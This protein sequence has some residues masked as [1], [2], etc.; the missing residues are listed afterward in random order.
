VYGW[1]V[2]VTDKLLKAGWPWNLPHPIRPAMLGL[3]RP[4]T[5]GLTAIERGTS[6][7]AL[8]SGDIAIGIPHDVPVAGYQAQNT[9]KRL[10]LWRAEATE[11][12]ISYAFNIGD[13]DGRRAGRSEHGEPLQ[14]ALPQMTHRRRAGA[15]GS[16]SQHFFVSCRPHML[17][18]SIC[19]SCP[20]ANFPIS[21]GGAAQRQ[22]IPRI[23]VAELIG[24]AR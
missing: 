19:A 10:R 14:G 6:G 4:H 17:R 3:R 21:W 13:Y 1:Q 20:S 22:P 15:C 16:S 24:C 23:A 7:V 12:F 2:E 11:N 8:D 5:Q 9:C 18:T